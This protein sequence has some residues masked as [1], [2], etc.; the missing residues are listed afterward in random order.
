MAIVPR[1]RTELQA[2][3]HPKWKSLTWKPGSPLPALSAGWQYST[4][5]K[6]RLSRCEAQEPVP[7]PPNACSPQNRFAGL[8]R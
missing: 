8:C 7:A 3:G 2:K 5:V 4:R 1:C 6:D